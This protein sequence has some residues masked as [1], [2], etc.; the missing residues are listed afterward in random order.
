VSAGASGGKLPASLEKNRRLSQWLRFGAGGTIEVR[1]GKVEIGQGIL[2]ALAQIVAEELEVAPS[3]VRMM[4]AVTGTSPDEGVTSGS[5][6]TQDSGTALRFA[7]AEA[8][9][10]LLE[11]AATKLDYPVETL[12]ISDGV[13]SG[14]AGARTTYWDLA[15]DALLERD[16]TASVAPRA[17][18]ART[19]VGRSA[20]RID[21]PD[22]VMGRP[23]YVHDLA[24]PGLLH[25]RVLRPPSPAATLATLDDAAT[26]AMPGVVAVVRDGSFVGVLADREETA[27]AAIGRLARGARWNES[28]SLPDAGDLASWLVKAPCETSQVAERGM[29][30]APRV[31]A[32]RRA[33]YTRPFV[34]HASIGPSCAIARWDG[35]TRLHVWSHTQG[36]YNL[37]SDLALVFAL[38]AADIVVEHAE[39]AGCYGH[40]GADDVALDAALLAR[41]APGQPVRVVWSREDELG[42]SPF[43]PA[44]AIEIAA[45]LDERGE[46][47]AWHGEVWSNGHTMRPGRAAK[48]TLLAASHLARPFD[49]PVSVNPPV[50]GGGGAERNAVPAYDFPAL[51]VTCHRMTEMPVRA[52]AL[53][54][55]GACANVFAIESFVDD[56]A[57]GRAEDPLA[58]RLRH[59]SDARARAVLEAA[60]RRAAWGTPPA[61]EG[62]GR[63]IAW[64]RYKGFGA[65]CAAVAEVELTHEVRVK[66]LVL[67]VDVGLAVNP[68]GVANQVEG[69][70]IQ[71]TSWTL[72]E[73]VRFDRT[74]ITSAAWEAYPILRFS[75]VPQVEVEVIQRA[76]E[77]SLG[78][79]EAAQGPVT[80]AIANAVRD[81]I[82]VRVRDLPIT[83]ERVAAATLAEEALA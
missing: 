4:R 3:R 31:H 58:W 59:L 56:L 49:R 16:A 40:N 63:G 17:P 22:K 81:A 82:G 18:S 71:A 54:S 47:M 5:L 25:G 46:V 51:R 74:R 62:H 2:T 33:R 21:L 65:Y 68:D 37:R 66:R 1:S 43:G 9:A 35:A 64:A 52:S 42:W 34:A 39:G 79:G 76:D 83:A 7:C 15:G 41:A 26:K 80:A 44:M 23:R 67:A 61:G 28:A 32:T 14:P 45:D 53:R 70:A 38:P 77:P 27:L 48:P 55:L 75:E 29:D 78:A 50:A 72:K 13:I 60:A 20:A 12:T 57:R 73:A 36:I 8:R 11:A 6:S 10:L 30:G 69:G 19:V 24:L